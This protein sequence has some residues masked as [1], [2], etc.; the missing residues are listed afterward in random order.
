MIIEKFL[1][2]GKY[3]GKK[4]TFTN[5]DPETHRAWSD[6]IPNKGKVKGEDGKTTNLPDG[7]WVDS[8]KVRWL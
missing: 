4:Y 6:D 7:R 2:V 1:R 3:G 8:D 5:Y